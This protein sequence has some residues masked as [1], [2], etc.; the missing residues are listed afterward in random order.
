[1]KERGGEKPYDP[2][3]KDARTITSKGVGLFQTYHLQSQEVT[4]G[5][6][7]EK[8]GMKRAILDRIVKQDLFKAGP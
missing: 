8:L 4:R 2:Q 1:M 5:R 6:G 7:I 3:R